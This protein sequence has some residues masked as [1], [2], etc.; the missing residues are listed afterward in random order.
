MALKGWKILRS[1]YTIAAIAF[2]ATTF[3][4]FRPH[5]LGKAYFWDDFTE[6]VYP[7]R[8]YAGRML[9]SGALPQWNPYSFC[10]MP[11]QADVQTALYYPPYLL[12]DRLIGAHRTNGV[13]WLQLLII[14]HFFLAQLTMYLLARQLGLTPSASG[15][16]AIGYAFAAPLALHTHHPM[17][18]EHLAWLPLVVLFLRRAIVTS[19]IAAIGWGGLVGGMMLLSGA[20][21]MSLYALS[22]CMIVSLWW[23]LSERDT[24]RG[25]LG[26]LGKAVAL[27]VL[28]VGVYG[29]QY[30]P[31]RELA[32]QSERA[33][34]SYEQATEG[35]LAPEQLLTALTPKAFGVALPPGVSNPMPYYGSGQSY[36]YWDTAFYF[37]IGIVALALWTA[38]CCWRESRLVKLLVTV[39][40][41]AVLFALGSNGFLYPLLYKLPLFGQV[42]I[43]ARMMFAAAFAG[44]LL[45]AYG[46]DRMA[47]SISPAMF[48][49]WLGVIACCAL[50]VVGVASGALVNPPERMVQAI[51]ASA[52]GQFVFL[53]LVATAALLR[54]RRVHSGWLGA[55]VAA[56][57]FFDLQSAHAAFSQ[58][59]TNPADEYRA[60]LPEELRQVLL[61]RPPE[62]V[63]RVSMR[64]PEIIAL[65]RNQGLVDGVMLFEGYN[66]LL[67]KRRHP[68]VASPERVADLLS[69]RWAIARDSLGRWAFRQRPTAFPMAWL[70]HNVRV[71]EPARVAEVMRSD[72]AFDYR[73]AAIVEEELPYPLGTNTERDSIGIVQYTPDRVRYYVR[74]SSAALAV[75]SEIFYPAW[76]AYVDG[77]RVPL[78]R[79]NYCLRG[80]FLPPGEHHLELRYESATFATGSLVTAA[81][82]ATA[83]ALVLGDLLRKIQR[84]RTKQMNPS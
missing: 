62:R 73:S 55:A 72:S 28:A 58:G 13:Y 60:A 57:V 63:F 44:T 2:L 11:F 32:E 35:S 42:R 59:R 56:I 83:A 24:W 45:A 75:L 6:Q 74:C 70:V 23:A 17:F 22:L 66:Q 36:L 26:G 21:Q 27:I 50:I 37:G 79:T 41:L 78:Y 40:M 30:F 53:G 8:V 16:A 48:R 43:P 5:I 54:L 76:N 1:E 68:A 15:I 77:E 51:S 69:I 4:F 49:T 71:V 82:L 81:S 18:I 31:S 39:A 46:W 65:K 84:R 14:A 7:N 3:L 80:V 19:S 52:W 12:F 20:P 47:R 10:G 67:L 29:I 38:V 33:S 64:Q 9:E 61:P 34:L 25:R